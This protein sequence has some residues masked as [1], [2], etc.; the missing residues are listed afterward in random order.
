MFFVQDPVR[1]ERCTGILAKLLEPPTATAS[2]NSF[3]YFQLYR[4]GLGGVIDF[5]SKNYY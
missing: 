1:A 3:F 5:L 4:V 2:K